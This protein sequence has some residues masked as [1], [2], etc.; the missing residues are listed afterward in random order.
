MI[1][2]LCVA[3]E[4]YACLFV[5]LLNRRQNQEGEE[6]KNKKEKNRIRIDSQTKGKRERL[7]HE[8]MCG[9]IYNYYLSIHIYSRI[10]SSTTMRLKKKMMMMM[11]TVCLRKRII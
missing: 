1:S 8:H 3:Y 7:T 6:K 10:G 2:F 5:C 11:T 9:V 4:F